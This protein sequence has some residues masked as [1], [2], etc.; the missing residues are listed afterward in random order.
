[1]LHITLPAAQAVALIDETLDVLDVY[2]PAHDKAFN[3]EIS[4]AEFIA[5]YEVLRPT[6]NLLTELIC[7]LDADVDQ[8][9]LDDYRSSP[10][11]LRFDLNVYRGLLTA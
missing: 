8:D 3:G 11:D 10:A 5:L 9:T 4:R 6:R 7:E 2:Q 1:M